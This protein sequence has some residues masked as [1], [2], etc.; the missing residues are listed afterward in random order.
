MSTGLTRREAIAAATASFAAFFGRRPASAQEREQWANWS[1]SVRWAPRRVERPSSVEEVV[2]AVRRAAGAGDVLRVTGTGHSFVPLCATDGSLALLTK[3]SGVE[4]IDT[5]RRRANVLAGTK[6]AALHEPLHAA[7][8][9][10]ETLPDIDRQALAGAIATD[11][12]GTGREIGSLSALVTAVRLV[13]GR[14]RVVDCSADE[15]P[16]ILQAARVHLGV[17][18]VLTHIEIRL[19]PAFRLL[20]RSWIASFDECMAELDSN[21]AG[22]RHFEFFWVSDRDACLMKSLDPTDETEDRESFEDDQGLVG[23]RVGW[24][25][26]I[27]ASQRNRRFNEIEYSLPAERGPDCLGEL[28]ELMLGK[29]RDVTWPLEYRTVKGDDI[30]LSTSHGRPTVTI[31]AHQAANLPYQPFFDDVEAVFRNH[32]GRPHWGKMHS[33]GAKQLS[34]LYPRWNDFL[35]VR[36]EL[37][38]EGRFLSPYTRELLLGA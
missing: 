21:I 31:S 16:D 17:L 15:R 8:L 32:D 14:G 1:R 10:M 24:S 38:P 30:W 19:V 5:E 36:E 12:H 13:D 27:F 18:G 3:M 25:G 11:T 7:G 20:E 28:R 2:A 37:D 22:H 34:E 9:A 33:L 26:L 29:H 23:E 6:L 4:S 35:K